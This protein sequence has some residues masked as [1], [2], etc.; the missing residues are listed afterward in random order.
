MLVGIFDLLWEIVEG[1]IKLFKKIRMESYLI[2][3][4]I[5]ISIAVTGLILINCD[6][7]YKGKCILHDREYKFEYGDYWK[8]TGSFLEIQ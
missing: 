3:S 8:Y 5:G 1:I 7:K 2:I 6:I 4:L